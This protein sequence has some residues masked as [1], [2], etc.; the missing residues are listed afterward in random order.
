MLVFNSRARSLEPEWLDT[1]PPEQREAI[2]SRRDLRKLNSLMGHHSLMA[3]L[4]RIAHAETAARCLVD[5]GSGDGHFILKVAQ[6]LRFHS[7]PRRMIVIDRQPSVAPAVLQQLEQFGW[8]VEQIAADVFDYVAQTAFTADT[9]AIANLFLHHF[10]SP[11][12]QVLFENLA[13]KAEAFAAC[14]PRRARFALL[15][16]KF[17]PLIGCNHVTRHDADISIRAGFRNHELSSLWLANPN[18]Q[19]IERPGGIFSHCFLAFKQSPVNK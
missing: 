3:N 5:L 15:S 9:F 13:Q 1:L 7:R 14:E 17:L 18:W 12:L 19:L 11:Q 6:R 16:A 10:E 2:Q 8:Q 4:L